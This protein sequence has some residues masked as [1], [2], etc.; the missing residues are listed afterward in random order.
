MNH[1]RIIMPVIFTFIL[2]AAIVFTFQHHFESAKV[3]PQV[4]M[5]S[6]V[7]L[8]VVT[9]LTIL[10]QNN[11]LKSNNPHHFTNSIMSAMLGKMFIGG[12]AVFI[13]VSMSGESFSKYGVFGGLI[14]YLVYLAVEVIVVSKLNRSKHGNA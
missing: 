11:A 1:L 14:M 8:L 13:Y 5:G 9:I 6:N 3:S 10:Y 12:I 4:L 7:L 2:L